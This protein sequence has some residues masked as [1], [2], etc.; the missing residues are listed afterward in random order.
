MD[1]PQSVSALIRSALEED[2]GCGDITS[3][4]IITEE[5]RSRAHI[6]AKD[7]LCSCRPSIRQ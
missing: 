6:I 5:H 1:I 3:S 7:E 2:I 4:L